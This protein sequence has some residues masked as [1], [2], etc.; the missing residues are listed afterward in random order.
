MNT[1][2]PVPEEIAV[3]VRELVE[4]GAY[5]D[6]ESAVRDAFRLLG[7]HRLREQLKSSL[8]E[9]EAQAERGELIE[10]NE[11]TRQ[12]IIEAGRAKAARGHRPN[13]DVCP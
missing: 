7:E 2:I 9:A 5:P 10:F 12:R 6:S 13:P 1:T 8:A 3:Q 4:A 11:E